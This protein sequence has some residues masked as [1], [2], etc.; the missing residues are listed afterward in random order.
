MIERGPC[1]ICGRPLPP[2]WHWWQRVMDALL[3][4]PPFHDPAKDPDCH[5]RLPS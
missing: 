2:R 3:P 4:P 5:V 1:L